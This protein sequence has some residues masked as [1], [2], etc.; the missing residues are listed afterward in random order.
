[1]PTD[2]HGLQQMVARAVRRVLAP[3]PHGIVAVPVNFAALARPSSLPAPRY[4]TLALLLALQGQAPVHLMDTS[5][6]TFPD[7]PHNSSTDAVGQLRELFKS[8]ASASSELPRFSK[9]SLPISHPLLSALARHCKD[10]SIKTLA[11]PA[12][13]SNL[14]TLMMQFPTIKAHGPNSTENHVSDQNE[15]GLLLPEVFSSL[16][17]T[18]IGE[19]LRQIKPRNSGLWGSR[20]PAAFSV[21]VVRPLLQFTETE[22]ANYCVSQES[23]IEMNRS[24]SKLLQELDTLLL[25]PTS[26]GKPSRFTADTNSTLASE[27]LKMS[28]SFLPILLK[29]RMGKDVIDLKRLGIDSPNGWEVTSD[30]RISAIDFGDVVAEISAAYEKLDQ[31]GT[32]ACH[33]PFSLSFGVSVQTVLESISLRDPPTGVCFFRIDPSADSSSSW[34]MNRPLAFAVLRELIQWTACSPKQSTKT[35]LKKIHRLIL[36]H[37]KIVPEKAP[38]Q[39][40]FKKKTLQN[41]VYASR[42]TLMTPPPRMEDSDLTN[43]DSSRLWTLGRAPFGSKL[44]TDPKLN[45]LIKNDQTK[46]WDNRFYV[47]VRHSRLPNENDSDTALPASSIIDVSNLRFAIRPFSLRDFQRIQDRMHH[48]IGTAFGTFTASELQR[49]KLVHYMRTMPHRSRHTIPCVSLVQDN[50]DC[51]YVVSIPSLGLSTE[52]G[53]V[54]VRI[55]YVGIASPVL[56]APWNADNET[57]ARIERSFFIIMQ[58][59]QQNLNENVTSESLTRSIEFLSEYESVVG[60]IVN[61]FAGASVEKH[62]VP[63][64]PPLYLEWIEFVEKQECLTGLRNYAQIYRDLAPYILNNE[65]FKE[66]RRIRDAKRASFRKVKSNQQFTEGHPALFDPIAKLIHDLP[67]FTFSVQ[68]YDEPQILPSEKS[69]K[70]YRTLD[71]VF[72]LSECMR[73]KHAKPSIN[74]RINETTHRNSHGFFMGPDT[75]VFKNSRMPLFSNAKTECFWDLVIPMGFHVNLVLDG[76]APDEIPWDEKQDVL[77]WRGSATGGRFDESVP[78]RRY[79]RIR[80]VEWFHKFQ[81]RY[82]YN[83]FDAGQTHPPKLPHSPEASSGS[84]SW[85]AVDVGF[86]AVDVRSKDVQRQI[87]EEYPLRSYVSFED[88]IAFKYLLVVDGNSENVLSEVVAQ[89]HDFFVAWPNRVPR[90]LASNSVVLLSTAFTDW[91]MWMLEPFVHFVPVKLDFSD[92]EERLLWLRDNDESARNISRNARELMQKINRIEQ[93]QCYTALMMIEYSRIHR[94]FGKGIQKTF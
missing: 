21:D 70:P 68:R 43:S 59:M 13:L 47:T 63:R 48:G 90:Y 73:D 38:K 42:L 25:S 75:F 85:L 87:I 44:E 39:L 86:H 9:T 84:L 56:D 2:T 8:L 51:N 12:S 31:Q 45:V 10:L 36:E 22:L 93:M 76:V 23:I 64:I 78:W 77:F 29:R 26:E 91:F 82:P 55:S 52:V 80:L 11:T 1:M 66:L 35:Q 3:H 6:F 5:T 67:E 7:A 57:E 14:H 81:L 30:T 20:D 41:V 89:K 62:L 4:T 46:L 72:E 34:L 71:D 58:Q 79:H 28:E 92:L 32:F 83:T 16:N 94:N 74:N 19:L 54:D 88:T 53:L 33:P 17:D 18:T 65:G 60:Q 50:G 49:Q 24:P 37:L 27:R 40:H 69:S 15:N 61:S